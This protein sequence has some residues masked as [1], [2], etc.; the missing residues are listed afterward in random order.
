[1][2]LPDGSPNP[3]YRRWRRAHGSEAEA[4]YRHSEKAK[5]CR[6]R[7]RASAKAKA[8]EKARADKLKHERHENG[9]VVPRGHYRCVECRLH[10]DQAEAIVRGC[11]FLGPPAQ[12]ICNECLQD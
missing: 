8:Y 7:F 5:A 2:K 12:M 6:Q 10:L 9:A 3:A 1:M 4:R 11:R